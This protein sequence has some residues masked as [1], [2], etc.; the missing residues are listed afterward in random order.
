MQPD[1]KLLVEK[2]K[3]KRPLIGFYD[4]PDPEM[5]APIVAPKAGIR[6]CMFD[7][8]AD[9]MSGKTTMFTADNFG[10]GGCGRAF[11]G[12]EMQSREDFLEFL[13]GKEGLKDSKETMNE[14]IENS[15]PKKNEFGKL[16]VGPLKPE[17]YEFLKTVT[18]FINA[19][20]LS[21]FIY[22]AHYHAKLNRKRDAINH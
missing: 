3:I 2:I 9:W 5:F 18:F 13:V 11:F 10:C 21:M 12:V 8:Y 7:F 14:W 16:F 20:Q 19:D 22:G 4:A 6:N 15:T 1:Y 17:A